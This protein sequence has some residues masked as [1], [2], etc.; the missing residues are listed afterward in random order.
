MMELRDVL[1]GLARWAASGAVS[2][3]YAPLICG[4][5]LVSRQ[6]AYGLSRQWSRAQLRVFGVAL[7]VVQEEPLEENRRYVFA[8]LNQT[9]LIEFFLAPLLMPRP[10]RSVINLEFA[11]FPLVGQMA[12]ALGATV[13]VRQWPAQAKRALERAVRRLKDGESFFISVE[14]RRSPDG[15]LSRYRKG[16]VVLAIGAQVDMVPFYLEGAREILPYGAWVP[17]PGRV[18]AVFMRPIQV[19]GLGYQ[20]RDALLERVCNAAAKSLGQ[21]PPLR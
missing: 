1:G 5:A 19:A 9:S 17:R 11:L 21:Q 15:R 2:V 16:S 3:I 12:V 8:H 4:T 20:D 18:R 14:G 7:E 6:A 13:I 10:I